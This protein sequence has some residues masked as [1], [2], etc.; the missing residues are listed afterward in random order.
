MRFEYA[1]DSG[2]GVA[3][4]DGDGDQDVFA[5]GNRDNHRVWWNDGSGRFTLN[6]GTQ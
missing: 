6:E 2:V 5:G 1:E 4:F 3:D